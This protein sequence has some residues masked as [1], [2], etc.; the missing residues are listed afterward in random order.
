M[1]GLSDTPDPRTATLPD[2]IPAGAAGPDRS[3]RVIGETSYLWYEPG[4]STLVVPF[5][6]LATLDHPYP[7]Q[8]WLARHLRQMGY[9]LLGVQS[10]RKDWFRGTDVPVLLTAL[11]ENGFFEGFE[12]IIFV[13]ASM[14]GFGA[15]NYAPLVPRATVLALSPQSTMNRNIAPFENRFPW[16]VRNSDWTHPRLLDA[17]DAIP[18]IPQATI[19]YDPF[20]HADKAH[21]VRLSGPNVQLAPVPHATHEAVRTVMKSGAFEAMLREFIDTGRLGPAFRQAMRGRR[22]TRKWARAFVDNLAASHHT[23]LALRAYDQLVASENYL[24]AMQA[25]RE[26]LE[27]RPELGEH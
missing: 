1:T 5:D 24:F 21:A 2:D 7:R 18:D 20:E 3:F 22:K 15:I 6:N 12:R 10:Q 16:A 19:V 9:A 26:L 23:K 14:G 17:A 25:R 8:P 4:S 11:R 27:A 13:G